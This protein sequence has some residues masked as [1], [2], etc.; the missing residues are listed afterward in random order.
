MNFYTGYCQW[1]LKEWDGLLLEQHWGEDWPPSGGISVAQINSWVCYIWRKG[2]SFCHLQK[3]NS[4]SLY[5]PGESTTW[6]TLFCGSDFPLSWNNG[7]TKKKK[8]PYFSWQIR[9]PWFKSLSLSFPSV[10][11]G[12]TLMIKTA[13]MKWEYRDFEEYTCH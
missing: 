4:Q 1:Y 5:R 9:R 13:T 11:L 6:V 10:L 2:L 7:M 8:Q 12:E 3:Q